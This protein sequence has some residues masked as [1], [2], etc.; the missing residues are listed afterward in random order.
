MDIFA[1]SFRQAWYLSYIFE[2]FL[3]RKKSRHNLICC[4]D[5]GWKKI[6]YNLEMKWHICCH[7]P[8]KHPSRNAR[9]FSDHVWHSHTSKTMNKVSKDFVTS[10]ILITKT[11]SLE[12]FQNIQETCFFGEEIPEYSRWSHPAF[13]SR[14][15]QL[16]R[17]PYITLRYL[18]NK[19]IIYA[20]LW[21]A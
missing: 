7:D 16:T 10:E 21:P 11:C 20:Y 4:W 12:C 15:W 3:K 5:E 1:K 2:F 6:E 13:W 18:I 9:T 14:D 17:S 19:K 8:H